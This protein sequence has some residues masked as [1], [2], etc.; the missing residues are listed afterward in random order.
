[1]S[2]LKKLEIKR[3]LNELSYIESDFDY[4]SEIIYEADNSFINCVNEFL[5]EHIEIKEV[6]D[7]RINS[8]I[9]NI[10]KLKIES[11]EVLI[12]KTKENLKL[13]KIYRDI[14]KKTHPDKIVDK[15]LNDFYIKASESY[16]I[17]DPITMYSICNQLNIEYIIDESD[18]QF[19]KEKIED[20]KKRI[21]FMELTYTF[22]W[23]NSDDENE[24]N[25]IIVNY[26]KEQIK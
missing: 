10:I 5:D 12:K 6:F 24:R 7:K 17:N 19:I 25:K 15:R 13:K 18:T 3:L 11:P 1:M 21:S 9:D 26:I 20:I 8:R 4:K 22:K 23:Y 16:E 2:N 14:A